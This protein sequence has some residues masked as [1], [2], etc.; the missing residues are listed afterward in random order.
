VTRVEG[1]LRI[2]WLSPAFEFF[3]RR[4]SRGQ[5]GVL[6]AD[7]RGASMKFPVVRS[8]D[9]DDWILADGHY[10]MSMER[11]TSKERDAVLFEARCELHDETL[12]PVEYLAHR[13]A[14]IHHVGR[15]ALGFQV[16][17]RPSMLDACVGIGLEFTEDGVGRAVDA[18]QR[19][20]EH[21]GG[22]RSGRKFSLEMVATG[23]VF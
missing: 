2:E 15:S 10:L 14:F 12:V 16:P 18:Q 4:E 8:L 6:I 1:A 23:A 21:L 11:M 5:L 20:H 13:G 7:G 9:K 22:W 19:L 3:D 17:V